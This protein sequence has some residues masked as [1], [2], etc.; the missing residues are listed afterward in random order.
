M[1]GFRSKAPH[2]A[3]QSPTLEASGLVGADVARNIRLEKPLGV[4]PRNG[5]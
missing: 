4:L 5:A 1:C 3:R 2:V